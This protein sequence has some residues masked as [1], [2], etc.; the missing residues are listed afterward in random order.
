MLD[1]NIC[2]DSGD[3]MKQDFQD[4]PL[5]FTFRHHAMQNQINSYSDITIVNMFIFL[6]SSLLHLTTAQNVLR[7]IGRSNFILNS[8]PDDESAGLHRSNAPAQHQCQGG[9]GCQPRV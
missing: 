7:I 8:N 3:F 4:L 9:S 1:L 2:S 5:M 6:V